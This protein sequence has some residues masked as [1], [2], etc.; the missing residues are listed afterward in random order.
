VAPVVEALRLF[1]VDAPT[2]RPCPARGGS[3]R[4]QDL[5]LQVAGQAR[6]LDEAGVAFSSAVV[7]ARQAGCSWRL[8]ARAAGL[9]HQTLHRRYAGQGDRVGGK[10]CEGNVDLPAGL[11]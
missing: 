7:A 11:T 8:V 3:Y 9:P 5:L 10:T 6:A 4:A 1:D 2:Q